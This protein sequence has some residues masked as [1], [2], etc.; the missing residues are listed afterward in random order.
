MI[1][2]RSPPSLWRC[3]LLSSH[4]ADELL[5]YLLGLF[6]GLLVLSCCS[7][8]ISNLEGG[9]SSTQLYSQLLN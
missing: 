6:Q 1:S 5:L 4:E 9:T 3:L 7:Q 8:G 2:V